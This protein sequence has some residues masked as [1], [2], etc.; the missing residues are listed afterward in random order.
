M[1]TPRLVLLASV[2]SGIA[3]LAAAHLV[4]VRRRRPRFLA[5]GYRALR[6]PRQ[7]RQLAGSV[8]ERMCR[9][10]LLRE[11]RS[12]SRQADDE[13]GLVGAESQAAAPGKE[14]AG[15]ALDHPVDAQGQRRARLWREDGVA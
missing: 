9:Q 14:F 5:G 4:Q 2:L 8:Q 1:R 13:H 12:R 6:D 15:V 10:D 3:A 7:V 11:R